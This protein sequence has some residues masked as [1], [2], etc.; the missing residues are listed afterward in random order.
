[1]VGGQRLGNWETLAVGLA[2]GLLAHAAPVAAAALLMAV[3]AFLF[4][5][6]S[7]TAVDAGLAPL[8][9]LG[10]VACAAMIG[11]PQ[12]TIIAAL[13][14]RTG[15]ELHARGSVARDAPVA[16]HVHLWAAP[17]VALLYKVEAPA[18]LV[19]AAL[20]I[21]GVA[22][23]DWLIRRLADWRLDAPAAE[24]ARTFFG[25]QAAIL[26]PLIIFP[27]PQTCL[28]ALVAMGA[29]RALHWRPAVTLRYATARY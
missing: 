23:T 13:I 19:V 4:R 14:W 22:W 7:D 16:A 6:Q 21:A 28:A 12:A 11:G 18:L 1:M 27:A 9:S 15:V 10:L 24:A 5:A 20:C 2:V 8:A 25:A 29:A 3:L 26:L 17:A